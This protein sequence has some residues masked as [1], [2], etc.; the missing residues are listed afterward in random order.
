MKRVGWLVV[1]GLLLILIPAGAQGPDDRFVVVYGLIQQGDALAAAGRTSEARER[2]R[3][4]LVQLQQLDKD[5]P[6]W[7]QQIVEFRKQYLEARVGT[8]TA[9]TEPRSV[10]APTTE[11]TADDPRLAAIEAELGQIKAER[12]LLQA[13]LR[14]ALTAQP[15]A[16]DPRELAKAD[17]RAA[18]FQREA[19][20][21]R[22]ALAV[23]EQELAAARLP[24]RIEETETALAAARQALVEQTN[25]LSALM[26]EKADVQKQLEEALERAAAPA[27]VRVEPT[28]PAQPP[29]NPESVQQLNAANIQIADLRGRVQR[30]EGDLT[31]ERERSRTLQDE[32]GSLERQ[33]AELKSAP[34]PVPQPA[35]NPQAEQQLV[36][37]NAQMSDLR[38]RVQRLE[39]ELAGERDRLRTY[40][41]EK[42]LLE[43]RVAE[44]KSE[45]E[46]LAKATPVPTP[47]PAPVAVPT[48]T[49]ST[50]PAA[51]PAKEASED[52]KREKALAKYQ[53]GTDKAKIQQLERERDELTKRLRV[54][55]RRVED[56][57]RQSGGTNLT[58]GT[59]QLAILRARLEAYE[60]RAVPYSPEEMALMKQ[61]AV[62][63]IPADTRKAQRQLRQIPAGAGTLLEEAKQAFIL[64]RYDAAEGKLQQALQ[65]DERNADMLTYLAAAQLEQ[66]RL[67]QAEV[68]LKRALEVDPQNADGVSLMGLLRFRQERYDDAFDL[69][70]QAA[71]LNPDNPYTQNYLGVT[72]SQRGQRKPAEAALRRAV[73]LDPNYGEAHANLAAVYALQQPPYLELA[74]WHYDKALALGGRPNAEIEKRLATAGAATAP[75]NP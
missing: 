39:T 6:R 65:L 25:R 23:K 2:Y 1:C 49:A 14:E 36:A 73:A 17:E 48:S 12:D 51:E 31:G 4:A 37:A 74:R 44:L 13:K 72:L 16:L 61:S 30:L 21:L 41:G 63:N 58:S 40:Q 57:R 67:D 55:T 54:M 7:N 52:P 42:T 8:P 47:A 34:A 70:S 10:G 69:L 53:R 9:P 3:E 26:R 50:T 24:G 71:Q 45:N 59:D 33:I 19:E 46:Q 27:P 43:Q 66:D 15:A 5:F 18:A 22:S 11:K 38:Q 28:P 62:A 56:M 68:N 32:K 35:A 64:R 29:A 20:S 75:A 60:A